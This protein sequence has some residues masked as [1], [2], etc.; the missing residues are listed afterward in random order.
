MVSARARE[1]KK[2]GKL[3]IRMSPSNKTHQWCFPAK[4]LYEVVTKIYLKENVFSKLP[5]F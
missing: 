5:G 3:L 2:S 1:A 4:A